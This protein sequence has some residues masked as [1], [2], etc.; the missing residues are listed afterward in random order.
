MDPQTSRR[1]HRLEFAA[2][3]G[4]RYPSTEMTRN[5]RMRIAARGIAVYLILL[6]LHLCGQVPPPLLVRAR[7]RRIVGPAV[8]RDIH[9]D[10]YSSFPKETDKHAIVADTLQLRNGDTVS[11]ILERIS[12]AVAVLRSDLL[13]EPLRIP[14]KN[15]R[16]IEFKDAAEGSSQRRYRA[17]AFFA[18]GDSLRIDVT[19]YDGQR[20]TA[21]ADLSPECQMEAKHLLGIVFER[22]PRV[23]YQ[24]DFEN[25]SS[26]AFKSTSGNWTVS[27]G[28]FGPSD[29]ADWTGAYLRL[30]QE[31]HVRYRWTQSEEDNRGTEAWFAFFAQHHDH[32]A[33][34]EAYQVRSSPFNVTLYRTIQNNAQ[35]IATFGLRT[36]RNTRRL[37]VE[38][39]SRTGLFR[40][41]VDGEELTAGIFASPISQGEYVVLGAQ[42]KRRFD[43]IVI[44]Q[45]SEGVLPEKGQAADATDCVVLTNG[46]RLSGK[47]IALSEEKARMETEYSGTTTEIPFREISAVRFGGGGTVQG[48]GVRGQGSGSEGEVGETAEPPV[49]FFRNGDRLRGEVEEYDGGSLRLKSPCLGEVELDAKGVSSI[50]FGGDE[51]EGVPMPLTVGWEDRAWDS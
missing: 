38:Y 21:T 6:T 45:L 50:D 7:N 12:E 33:P 36:R 17:K 27:R 48:S 13:P 29:Q 49:V 22:D 18:N 42:G 4:L 15:I 23:L 51:M 30:R 5:R 25:G 43:D 40:L 41:K 46:D 39:D 11:G 14:L 28:A 3:A 1:A 16:E 34:G 44:E 32:F 47:L 31:G 19:A 20:L 26:A 24:A 35:H 9:S 10:Q 2:P 8:Y 37:E